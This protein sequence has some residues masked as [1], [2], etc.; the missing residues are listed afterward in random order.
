MQHGA[1]LLEQRM[2]ARV[3]SRAPPGRPPGRRLAVSR[4]LETQRQLWAEQRLSQAQLRY[5]SLLGAC[6]R[7]W[8]IVCSGGG[9]SKEVQIDSCCLLIKIKTVGQ[10]S[11]G[12]LLHCYQRYDTPVGLPCHVLPL[13]QIQTAV[14]VSS[15]LFPLMFLTTFLWS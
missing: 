2:R 1:L 13:F 8:K 15:A 12:L 9:A 10:S 5:L 7:C 14:M 11:V 4:W 6:Q 3:R